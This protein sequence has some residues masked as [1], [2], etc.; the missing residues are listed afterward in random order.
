MI[1]ALIYLRLTSL[2]NLV[3]YRIGRL[4]QPKYLI[5]TAVAVVYF[6][7][8]LLRRPGMAGGPGAAPGMAGAGMVGMAVLCVGISALA[9]ARIAY[10][11]ISPA[12]KPGLRF[13]EAEIAFLFP[14]PVT[15]KT[16]I[17]FRLLSAQLAILFTA[18]LIAFF[19]NRFAFIGGNRVMRAVGWWVILSTFD[20]H[21]N[22]TNLTLSRL[23]ERSSGYVLW[24]TAV[25]AAIALYVA[26]V[27]WSAAVFVRGVPPSDFS[28]SRDMVGFVQA[29][30]A[31]SPLHWLVLPF[32]IVFGPYFAS[33]ARDFGL[34]MVP[35]LTVLALHYYWVSNTGAA[36]EEGSIALAEKR[37]ALKAAA[38]SGDL[39]KLGKPK[40]R[41]G[42]FP[43][44]SLGP[45]E[46]AFL[47]KNLISMRSSLLNRRIVLVTLWLVICLS[48]AMRPIIAGHARSS[49]YDVYGPMIAL[50]CAML[51]GYTLLLGPQMVRQD[52]RNDLPNADILKTYPL[53]GWRLA[54]GELLAPTAIL[55]L[56]LWFSILVCA[57]AIDSRGAI[58]WLTPGVRV[59]TALCMA[60]AAPVICFIQLIVPNLVM[61]LMPGWYQSSRSRAP[62]IEMFGQR[63]IFGVAQL[64]ASL[65]I[66]LPAA[67]A[68]ALVI[69]SFQRFSV[70]GSIAAA[71]AVVLTI[72]ASEAAVGLWLLGWRFEKFDLSAEIR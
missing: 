40:A 11:W 5:G 68:A 64:L 18:V 41:S 72:L 60:S 17:H 13:S 14:A 38:Q 30:L 49:G 35:A 26:A 21:I 12:E 9:L 29:L 66:A 48:F 15:R 34:A 42:P 53:E 52:L 22:G 4:R 28:S 37:A 2:R 20:L 25:V 56:S 50:F 6:Y 47:W 1:G 33:G 69:F 61:V 32:R 67:G 62:G 65:L 24:R 57:L 58:A 71:C 54:L 23:R 51:A 70:S 19:F 43:L 36:F 63:L 44:S 10:V 55:S 16:L 46:I 27:V 45:P 31:S 39:S 7:Y 8:V 3:A 59:T